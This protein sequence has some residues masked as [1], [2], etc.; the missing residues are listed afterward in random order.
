MHFVQI[1]PLTLPV[2]H[3]M[4]TPPDTPDVGYVYKKYSLHYTTVTY[5]PLLHYTVHYTTYTLGFEFR[6]SDSVSSFFAK[7]SGMMY[8][9]VRSVP[10]N[11]PITQHTH[12]LI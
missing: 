4:L 1:S 11:I 6:F 8:S 12:T 5:V 3:M 9:S 7:V 10:H 2:L